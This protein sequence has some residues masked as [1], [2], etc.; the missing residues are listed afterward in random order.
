MHGQT[1]ACTLDIASPWAP[2][3]AK[4]QKFGVPLSTVDSFYFYSPLYFSG[5]Y[6][7]HFHYEL[8]LVK[9]MVTLLIAG[10]VNDVLRRLHSRFPTEMER[11][12]DR[13]GLKL[14]RSGMPDGYNGPQLDK[15]LREESINLLSEMIPQGGVIVEGCQDYMLRLKELYLMCVRSLL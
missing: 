12:L 3:G 1:H 13:L 9:S 8:F 6:C 10:A 5:F 4:K 7:F 14:G 11:Y 15:V 2:V